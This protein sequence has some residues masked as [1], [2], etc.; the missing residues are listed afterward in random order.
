VSISG[1]IE[2]A[3]ERSASTGNSTL[4]IFAKSPRGWKLPEYSEEQFKL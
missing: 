4:M 2:K 3:F 1:G